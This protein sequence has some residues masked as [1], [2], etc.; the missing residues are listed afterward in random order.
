MSVSLTSLKPD[1]EGQFA[2]VNM[3]NGQW[4]GVTALAH[5]YG[6]LVQ[7]WNGCHDGQ[8]YTPDQLRLTAT[9]LREAAAI[10]SGLETLA[11]A[12]GAVLS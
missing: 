6:V 10:A 2:E 3:P 12:G 1:K 8:T 5:Q 4:L 11:D 7:P 9:R